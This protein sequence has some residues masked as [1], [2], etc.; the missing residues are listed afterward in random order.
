[1]RRGEDMLMMRFRFSLERIR[2][3]ALR[4]A[5][6]GLA[7]ALLW[8][9]APT[10][11]AAAIC[12]GDCNGD[13]R[14]TIAELQACVNLG[15]DLP[16]PP[17]A[18]ADLDGGGVDANDVDACVDSFLDPATCPMV[19]TPVVTNTPA[20]TST[21]TR[22][23][24]AAPTN[25]PV[26]TA[27]RTST[28]SP[29]NTPTIA[30]TATVTPTNTAPPLGVKECQLQN[31]SNLGLFTQALPLALPPT[32]RLSI[33]CGSVG[34]EGRAECSCDLIE[35]DAV[36]IPSIGDVC[37]NPSGGC[38]PGAIDC[39]GGS[40]LDVAVEAEHNIGECTSNA[41]CATACE[42]KCDGLGAEYSLLQSGC[43]GYCQGGTKN[44]ESCLND[45]DCT[46]GQCPGRDPVT[47]IGT[48]NCTCAGAGLGPASVPG[49]L[50]CNLG[51]QINVELPSN[52]ACGDTATIRLPQI[53]GGLTTE[54]ASGV[55]RDANNTAN[56]TIPRFPPFL[57]DG[58]AISCTN[59]AAGN[60][61]GLK[62]VG[63]LSFF[64]STLGD[65]QSSNAFACQ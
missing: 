44:E 27:T 61:T 15:A 45:V 34:A 35:L 54:T 60:L 10:G 22:T 29:T 55:L 49:G 50:T 2:P 51:I 40:K 37:V 32:G 46:G 28:A 53:C 21:V 33:S 12:A 43:E 57:S 56:K 64:D 6:I 19:P 14:V 17:C 5:G 9:C 42:A 26:P 23:N 3:L 59:F 11:R 31:T 20:P 18:A 1:M 41:A 58:A 8:F 38:V 63:Q 24:T 48:C 30:P 65:I 39:D 62:L 13:G 36:V 25:T 16:A 52:G 4:P 47:H 7:L